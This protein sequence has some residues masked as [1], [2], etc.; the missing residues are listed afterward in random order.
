MALFGF[1]K[2]KK[3]AQKKE[4]TAEKHALPEAPAAQKKGAGISA[5][6]SDI[7]LN[8]R[9]TEKATFIGDAHNVYVFNVR[10]NATKP[11]VAKAVA[12][13]F[14]VHPIKVRIIAVPAKK[15]YGRGQRGTTSAGKKAYVYLAPGEKIELV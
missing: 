1:K 11:E 8:P 15:V 9:I 6:D 14:K 10:V 5:A 2:E 3:T 4:V 13:I 7:I 12:R